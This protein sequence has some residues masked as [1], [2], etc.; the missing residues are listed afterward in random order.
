MFRAI[1]H[2]RYCTTK[3]I[4]NLD[5]QR[6]FKKLLFETL[7][8]INLLIVLAP[9][10]ANQPQQVI[11][12]A[13]I[14]RQSTPSQTQIRWITNEPKGAPAN[15]YIQTVCGSVL[16]CVCTLRMLSLSLTVIVCFTHKKKEQTY[17]TSVHHKKVSTLNLCSM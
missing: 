15:P 5:S 1:I 13:N 14:K 7:T 9:C 17:S 11:R 6:R 3:F 10:Q 8:S 16:R 4:S 12:E 2:V